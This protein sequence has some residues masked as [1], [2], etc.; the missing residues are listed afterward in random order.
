MQGLITHL[1]SAFHQQSNMH[2]PSL[3]LETGRAGSSALGIPISS[4]YLPL[5]CSCVAH[6]HHDSAAVEAL[7]Q[8]LPLQ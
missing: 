5:V 8:Y 3:M 2:S 7:Y 4:P 6:T 1:L